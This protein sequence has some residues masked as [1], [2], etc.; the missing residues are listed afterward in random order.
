MYKIA[1]KNFYSLYPIYG[2]YKIL[3]MFLVLYIIS[4]LLIPDSIHRWLRDKEFACQ[5]GDSGSVPRLGSSPGE[6]DGN[7]LQ[8]SCLGNPLDRGP[9]SMGLQRVRHNL[10]TKR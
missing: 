3:V 6:G 1:F 4:L 7:L 8:Y 5:A 10:V 9:Q 2:Y